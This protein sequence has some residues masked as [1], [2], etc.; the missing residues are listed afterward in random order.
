MRAWKNFGKIMSVETVQN[1]MFERFASPP[2]LA[3][4]G[5]AGWRRASLEFC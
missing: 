1:S 5:E 2:R 4:F 3:V